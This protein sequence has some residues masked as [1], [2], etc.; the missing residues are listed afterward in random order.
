MM[1]HAKNV[2]KN[3]HLQETFREY[4]RHFLEYRVAY[5]RIWIVSAAVP[6]RLS[7]KQQCSVVTATS[8]YKLFALPFSFLAAAPP[9]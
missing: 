4:H 5:A 2:K 8:T 7:S 1:T 9:P 3:L 6:R